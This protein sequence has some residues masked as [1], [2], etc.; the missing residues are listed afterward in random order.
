MDKKMIVANILKKSLHQ[1][2]AAERILKG[3]GN[4]TYV[5][6]K[7]LTDPEWNPEGYRE[8]LEAFRIIYPEFKNTGFTINQ[9]IR[10]FKM[11]GYWEVDYNR[12][13]KVNQ[14]RIDRALRKAQLYIDAILS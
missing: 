14:Y 8:V 9:S 12:L 4:Y 5:P 1:Y 2:M 7:E 13:L 10:H 3:K 6:N 11:T